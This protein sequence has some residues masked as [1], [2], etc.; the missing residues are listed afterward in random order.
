MHLL[1]SCEAGQ[2]VHSPHK[3]NITFTAAGSACAASKPRWMEAA[4]KSKRC[5]ISGL[6]STRS[7]ASSDKHS[8]YCGSSRR[9][10]IGRQ[11][12]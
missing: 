12:G 8:G 6:T 7:D 9:V 11:G 3:W 1:V 4:L 10:G 2:A 5:V